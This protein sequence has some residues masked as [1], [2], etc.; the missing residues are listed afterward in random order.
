MWS[1][2][3]NY[4][5]S[6]H[7]PEM[8]S[9]LGPPQSF[10]CF[11]YERMN[12]FLA[13]TPSNNRS[14]E[15]EVADRFVRDTAFSNSDTPII[16]TSNI[17]IPNSLKDFISQPDDGKYPLYPCIFYP[18]TRIAI[19]LKCSKTSTEALLKTGQFFKHPSQKN[20]RCTPNLQTEI[21]EFFHDLYGIKLEFISPRIEKFER[22]EVNGQTFSGDCN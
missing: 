11:G 4:H 6:L 12:G 10:W 19:N 5:M 18:E 21:H 9:D 1:V 14:V 22:C 20:V 8:I 15:V 3:V 2:S 16:D 17:C 7:L 13:G